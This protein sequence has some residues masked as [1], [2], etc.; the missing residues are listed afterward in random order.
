MLKGVGRLH[1][2]DWPLRQLT[3]LLF[4]MLPVV[5]ADAQQDPRFH[6]GQQTDHVGLGRGYSEFAEKVTLNV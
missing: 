5:Q 6:R 4:Y 2:Q 3:C 1:E